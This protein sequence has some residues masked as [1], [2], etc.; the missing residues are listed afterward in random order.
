MA[1]VFSTCATDPLAATNIPLGRVLVI[2]KPCER[3][4]CCTAATEARAGAYL[5]L[6]AAPDSQCP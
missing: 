2:V 3:S 6:K 5:A 1:N 4:Q